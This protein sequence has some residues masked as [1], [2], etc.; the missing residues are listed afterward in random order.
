MTHVLTVKL[1]DG[2]E[3][4]VHM[5]NPGQSFP[6]FGGSSR[7]LIASKTASLITRTKTVGMSDY[8]QDIFAPTFWKWIADRINDP[9]GVV[10]IVP[11]QTKKET[12]T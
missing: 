8:E 7:P 5:L 10:A 4:E 2:G 11:E 1:P 12:T 6:G 9:K 3:I